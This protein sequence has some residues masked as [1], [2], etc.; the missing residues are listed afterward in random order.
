M[1]DFDG[2]NIGLVLAFLGAALA[3]LLLG[4]G[5]GLHVR[6]SIADGNTLACTH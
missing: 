3:A 1:F 6:Q 2:A 5:L 4:L